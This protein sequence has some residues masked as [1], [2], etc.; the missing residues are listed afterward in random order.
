[1]VDG[2]DTPEDEALP[3][4]DELAEIERAALS[5][6]RQAGEAIV[7]SLGTELEVEYKTEGKRG[8]EPTDPVSKI[9]HAVEALIRERLGVEWPDHAIIGEEVDEH[10]AADAVYTWAID[11]V[12]GTTNF[13]NGFPLYCASIGVLYRGR[14]VVGATWVSASRELRPGVLHARAGQGLSFEDEPLAVG[15]PDKRIRRPLAAAPGGSPGRTDRWDN[16][17]TGSAAL[18]CA[19]TAAG[20]FTQCSFGG[21][22]IWDLASGVALA[23]EAG[24]D[25]RVRRRGEWV[26]F[27]RF[28]APASVK[29]DREP[30]LRDWSEPLLIGRP[31]SVTHYLASRKRPGIVTSILRRMLGR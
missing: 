30:T 21:L 2:S 8:A 4:D 11:P 22:R 23:Q 25:V 5:F 13:I 27:D 19:Y 14:P 29:E 9:D 6:A 15:D 3:G 10:P 18:E 16:R 17:V 1:V 7:A 24:M 31:E 28:R 26:P 12:D 20:I